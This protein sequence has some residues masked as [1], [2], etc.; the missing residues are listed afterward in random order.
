MFPDYKL[1]RKNQ[2]VLPIV[3]DLYLDKESAIYYSKNGQDK[4]NESS[5]KKYISF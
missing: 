3:Y 2:A 5:T 4:G 1:R